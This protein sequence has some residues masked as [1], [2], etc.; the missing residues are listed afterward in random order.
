MAPLSEGDIELMTRVASMYYMD[1]STQAEIATAL[2]LSRPKVGRL[3]QRARDEG[4]VEITIR[5]HPALSAKLEAELVAH[6]RLSGAILV[7]D[8]VSEDAQRALAARAVGEL[9]SRSLH[10]GSAVAIGMGRNVGAVAQQLPHVAGR[11]CTFI[12]AM[13][14]SPQVGNGL[15]PDDICRRLAEAF[16]GRA[17]SLYAPAYA[18]STSSR[19]VF[20]R[21]SDVRETLAHAR[22]AGS[23][24]V[25]IGDARNDSAVVQMGCFSA[26]EM[27]RMRQAGAVGD[28]LGYFFD[29]EGHPVAAGMH[30][31]VVGL[32]AEDLRAIPRVIAVSS[33][34]GKT[35]SVLGALRTGIIDLLVT[36]VGTARQLLTL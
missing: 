21:H 28:M 1:N 22:A 4:V 17:E 2:S 32:S 11:S 10:D 3:L 27:A 8:Q 30:D 9:L 19:E 26:A 34:P 7:A 6:F 33:E 18:E 24:V 15:N 12:A 16:G 20:L 36:N 29:V 14:G 25:G 31:R 35:R 23:A 5:T 13:G